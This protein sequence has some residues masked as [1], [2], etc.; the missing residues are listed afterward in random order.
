MRKKKFDLYTFVAGKALKS[1]KAFP[2]KCNC[3][4]VVTILP[5][6]EDEFV[7]CHK[8]ESTIKI[9]VIDGDPGYIYGED[10]TGTILIPVQGSSAKPLSKDE[11]KKIIEDFEK[12]QKAI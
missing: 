6:F 1:G 9:L 11:Q 8:C 10:S 12:N 7:T 4:G 3:G 5:P 2:L